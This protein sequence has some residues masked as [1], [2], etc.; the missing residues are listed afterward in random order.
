MVSSYIYDDEEEDEIARGHAHFPT[1]L[2]ENIGLLFGRNTM[3]LQ[4]YLLKRLIMLPIIVVITI[5]INFMIINFAPGDP[6]VLLA[7]PE[8]PPE[9]L[10]RLREIMGL[11]RPLHERLIIYMSRMLSLNLGHSYTAGKPVFD[12]IVERLPATLILMLTAFVISTV[13]GIVIGV[14]SSRKP[15]SKTDNF[16]MIS[17]LVIYS[18]PQFWT[19]LIL[20]LI[21]GLSLKLLPIGGMVTSGATMSTIGY[22]VDVLRHL[23]LPA[24]VLALYQVV[25]YI[26]LTRASMLE[27][28]R[29]DYIVTA[30]GK[31]CTQNQVYF[32]HALRN[33]LLSVVTMIGLRMRFLFM[34]SLIVETVFAWPG[35]GRLTFDAIGERD[36]AIVMG[37]FFFISILVVLSTLI[38]DI[39]YAFLDPRIRYE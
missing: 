7:A 5:V 10:E 9:H 29:K 14:L 26:R 22:I 16:L 11:N 21:F 20:I 1:F 18:T 12:L 2:S 27:V 13:L 25:L 4:R 15:F 24:T 8:A 38:I 19:G 32:G 34:G 17:S 39:I 33:A 23:I 31:G 37:V 3:T 36:Y 6:A 35:I 28:L 30:R